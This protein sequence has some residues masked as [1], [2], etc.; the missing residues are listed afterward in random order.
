M[1]RRDP[2]K[3]RR[4]RTR[5]AD[6]LM[7]AA[8]SLCYALSVVLFSAPNDIAPGGVTGLATLANYLWQLP[9]GIMVLI[10]N[11]P[12]LFIGWRQLGRRFLLRT[13]LGLGLSSAAM[14]LLALFVPPFHG[15]P[16]LVC[17]FGGALAGLG[18]GLILSRGATTGGSEIVARL[19]ERRFPHI[20]IGRLILL[21]DAVVVLLSGLVYR[22]MA[23]P[24]YATVFIFVSSLTTDWLVYGGRRGRMAMILTDRQ[25]SVTRQIMDSLGRGVT[26]LDATGAYT[27][28][29]RKMI[30]CVVSREEAVPLKRLVF[31][32]DP[33]AFFMMLTTDEVLGFGWQP[34]QP[35]P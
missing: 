18:L 22:Q 34:T 17:L 35:L 28:S 11:I 10:I 21:V 12:L 29:E 24:L 33:A 5:L 26:L 25:E 31:A 1:T 9:I 20:P 15:E 23:S 4:M 3:S 16:L 2:D 8:G 27:G 7:I 13:L 32:A 30:L 19:L 14:D 6:L